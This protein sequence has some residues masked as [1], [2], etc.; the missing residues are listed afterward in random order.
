MK[1]VITIL[2]FLLFFI[3]LSFS[4]TKQGNFV[5]S[6][7]TNISLLFSKLSANSA[8]EPDAKTKSQDYSVNARIGYFLIDN[9]AINLSSSYIYSYGRSPF[10]GEKIDQTWSVLPSLTYFI[11]VE[12]NFK[13]TIQFGAGYASLKERNSQNSS[14]DN[15]VYHFAGLAL[16]GSAGA[17]YF[18]NKSFSVDLNFQYSRNK[19]NDITKTSRSQIQTSYGVMTGI[20]VYF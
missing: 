7:G 16:A 10:Q 13:P 17:S 14:A 18:I 5:V 3:N 12:G 6:G 11:P 4:Q 8:D 9:L 1:K 15:V 19:L 20:S 2:I